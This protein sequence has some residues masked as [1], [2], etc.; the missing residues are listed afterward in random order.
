MLVLFIAFLKAARNQRGK[1]DGGVRD[2]RPY[3]CTLMITGE[4]RPQEAS[5]T[6]RVIN[7]T[8]S[9][10]DLDKLSFVQKHLKLMPVIGYRWL[11]YLSNKSNM[12]G[13]EETRSTKNLEF[14]KKVYTNPG[15]MA[16]NYS[17][18]KASW[19]LLC[20]SS[21]GD[22]FKEFTDRFNVVLDEAF[23]EQGNMVTEETEV[24]K[25]LNA[26][27][28]L[29]A[30]NPMLILDKDPDKAEA[31]SASD[32]FIGRPSRAI[33]K[34]YPDGL[35][36]LPEK[37]L[38]EL[39]KMRMFTQKPSEDSMT[40]ALCSIGALIIA[41][42]GRSKVEKRFNKVKVRGWLLSP[43]VIELSPPDGDAENSDSGYNVSSASRSPQ[44]NQN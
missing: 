32:E 20:E 16:T 42:D 39:E 19:K 5:T 21:F 6:A 25:F 43:H 38:A 40:R 12:E 35:F 1:K 24:S 27:R 18:M 36:L 29:I 22:V 13:Y 8:W 3:F 9:E 30:S 11:R 4:V 14:S 44:K 17:L 37:I 41:K 15:R 26:V 28:E 34:W 7:L 31:V 23:E 2:T 10:V 33:G